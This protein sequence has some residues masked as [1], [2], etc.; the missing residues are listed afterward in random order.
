MLKKTVSGLVVTVFISLLVMTLA[1]C[2]G[3][4][5]SGGGAAATPTA[6]PFSSLYIANP[7][8]GDILAYDNATTVS[9]NTAPS[10][11]ISGG[12]TQ[13]DA[14]LYAIAYDTQTKT[15]LAGNGVGSIL[16]FDN[17]PTVTGNTAPTRVL[18]GSNTGI[19][20]ASISYMALDESRDLLYVASSGDANIRVFAHASTIN[21]NVVPVRT[22][23]DTS[24]V[25]GDKRLVVDSKNDRLYCLYPTGLLVFNK[26]STDSGTVAPSR[27]IAGTNTTFNYAWGIALDPTRN[28]IYVADQGAATIDVFA[29]AD[30]ATGNIP[31]TRVITATA[32]GGAAGISLNPATDRLYAADANNNAVDIWDKVSTANGVVQPNRVIVGAATT[33]TG[34]ADIVGVP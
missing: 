2:G 13:L 4:S 9:G 18:T 28:L 33:F 15:V 7:N 11:T 14:S 32:L 23:T 34:D 24:L 19:P 31:P 3:G 27:T 1:G 29:N 17:A 26:A 25:P 5:G 22:F 8:N 12:S 20:A 6:T 30:T 16:F 21:G 10:R